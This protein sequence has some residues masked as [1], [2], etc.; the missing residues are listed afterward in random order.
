MDEQ[1][2]QYA[3]E[4]AKMHKQGSEF[5]RRLAYVSAFAFVVLSLVTGWALYGRFN[6]TNTIRE[7]N[8]EIWHAV[9]CDIEQSL[10]DQDGKIPAK[11]RKAALKFYDNLLV[12]DAHAAPCGL[13]PGG[14]K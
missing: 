14:K 9:V 12:K 4:L 10:V 6:E 11:Q 8:A 13:Y 2:N 3:Q 1:T 7:R 5:A